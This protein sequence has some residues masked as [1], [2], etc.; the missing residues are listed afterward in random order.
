[1]SESRTVLYPHTKGEAIEKYKSP[2]GDGNARIE[3]VAFG[4]MPI[5]KYKSP[6]GDGNDGKSVISDFT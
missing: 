5:E 3:Y 6:V 4:G 1:M 2:V